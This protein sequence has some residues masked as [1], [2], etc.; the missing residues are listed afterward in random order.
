[1]DV[2]IYWHFKIRPWHVSLLFLCEYQLLFSEGNILWLV[3]LLLIFKK[4]YLIQTLYLVFRSVTRSSKNPAL[5]VFSSNA[6]CFVL[7]PIRMII[8][9]RG[10]ITDIFYLGHQQDM[11]FKHLE[12]RQVF[13]CEQNLPNIPIIDPTQGRKECRFFFFLSIDLRDLPSKSK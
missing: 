12:E 4:I 8:F 10:C 13:L 7:I 2:K 6:Q 1:M 11:G 9:R 5:P 3:F